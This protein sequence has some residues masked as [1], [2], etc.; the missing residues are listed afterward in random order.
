MAKKSAFSCQDP[1][2]AKI[3]SLKR[4]GYCKEHWPESRRTHIVK[5]GYYGYGFCEGEFIPEE[6]GIVKDKYGYED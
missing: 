4:G 5:N 1:D 3:G 6:Y 2:C